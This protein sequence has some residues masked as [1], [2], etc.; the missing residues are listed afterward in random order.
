M[1]DFAT[2]VRGARDGLSNHGIVLARPPT[3]SYRMR[4]G[5]QIF[6][7]RKLRCIKMSRD[8]VYMKSELN[9]FYDRARKVL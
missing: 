5:L 3:V 8:F 6:G 2:Y 9:S 7:Q 1:L 4:C